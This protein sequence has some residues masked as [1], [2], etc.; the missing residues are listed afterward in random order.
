[1]AIAFLKG[2]IKVNPY[3]CTAVDCSG[4]ERLQQEKRDR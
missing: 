1:M 3:S 4:R 2:Y